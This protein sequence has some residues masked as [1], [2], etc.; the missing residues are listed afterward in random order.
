MAAT[1]VKITVK[2]AN[3]AVLSG[4]IDLG[5]YQIVAIQAPAAWT[6]G[7]LSFRGRAT[8]DASV[9]G[10]VVPAGSV[11]APPATAVT[12]D[13]GVANTAIVVTAAGMA[14]ANNYIAVAGNLRT[15]LQSIRHITLV[16][17]AAQGADRFI[18]LLCKPVVA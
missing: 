3:T 5:N 8:R 6:A 13:D 10:T 18:I 12:S 15:A 16:A 11:A 9:D 4:E 7:T 2:I 1:L 17:G 14:I